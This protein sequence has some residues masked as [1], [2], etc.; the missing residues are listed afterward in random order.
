MNRLTFIGLLGLATIVSSCDSNGVLDEAQDWIRP[1][2]TVHFVGDDDAAFG[3]NQ[4]ILDVQLIVTTIYGTDYSPDPVRVD[5]TVDD[6][7]TFEVVLPPDSVY[8]FRVRFLDNGQLVGE[9]GVLEFI[10]E[11]TS[12]VNIPVVPT[13]DGSRIGVIPSILQIKTA[14]TSVTLTIRYYGDDHGVAGIATRFAVTGANPV[15]VEFE[16]VESENPFI[17]EIDGTNASLAWQFADPVSGINDIGTI[18]VPLSESADFCIEIASDDARTVDR[19]GD[20]T[21]ISGTG[22]CIEITP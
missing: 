5:N 12:Q 19:G 13:G 17:L 18:R 6:Q 8:A 11:E 1:T 3:K 22:A 10:S 15:P 14:S 7:V 2:I 9:G 20:I 4:A 16:P 21:I